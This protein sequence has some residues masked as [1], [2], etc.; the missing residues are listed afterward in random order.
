MKIFRIEQV[1][2]IDS[3]T[4]QHEPIA[5]IDLMER[6]AHALFGWFRN[7]FHN[8]RKV[9]I[10]CGPGNN[11]GDGLAL[12]RM[13]LNVGY[14]V[15]TYYLS[16]KSYSEDFNTNLVRL[17]ESSSSIYMINGPKD[18]PKIEPDDI[19]VDALFGSGLS[20]TI[21]GLAAELISFINS[22]NAF[23][24]AIDIPSG[25]FGEEN[26]VPNSNPV[27]RANYCLSLQFPKI[28]FFMPENEEYVK[29]WR[30]LPIGLHPDAIEQTP[31]PYF[32]TTL[33]DISTNLLNQ[34]K[35]AH[36][37]SFGHVLIMAGS[38]GMMGAACLCSKASVR[39]GV[40]LATLFIPK[41]GY[42]IVQT[43]VPEA[44]ALTDSNDTHL[45]GY[46][47]LNKFTAICV[48]PGIGQDTETASMISSLIKN[49]TK[50]LVIDADGLNLISKNI[51][52]LQELKAPA[53]LTPHPGEFDRLFGKSSSSWEQ[54][55]KAISMAQRY[56]V[57][58][59]LKGAYTRVVLPNGEVHFNSTGNSGMATGGSGDVL[60]GIIAGL[61]ARGLD[62]KDAAITGVFV[63]GLAGDLAAD[64]FGKVSLCATDILNYI[65]KAFQHLTK[66]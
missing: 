6:A 37:G 24:V 10:F 56:G 36:K 4:I 64:D 1:K 47:D 28:A 57:I 54:L 25:L 35:F 34:S 9:I 39:S 26:P 29:D 21:E 20:R 11:G 30:T 18:F 44:L 65:C 12:A 23:V 19:I 58:I 41:C 3:Y 59:V 49:S 40:G 14:N 16:S 48:G 62:P 32:Y 2:L 53:I 7:R 46:P 8:N 17:K 13:L 63:H 15:H 31:S 66:K 33:S 27:V 52:L 38:Y 43:A 5:S 42:E 50:P 55:Q 22:S 61:L 51:D 60:S 45:T